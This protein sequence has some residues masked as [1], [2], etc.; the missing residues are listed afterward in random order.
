MLTKLPRPGIAASRSTGILTQLFGFRS[1]A[2]ILQTQRTR[3]SPKSIPSAANLNAL[4]KNKAR[5]I[6]EFIFQKFA[7]T[8]CKIFV[9]ASGSMWGRVWRNT[10]LMRGNLIFHRTYLYPSKCLEKCRRFCCGIMLYNPKRSYSLPH[11]WF[12]ANIYMR[13]ALE[14]KQGCSKWPP[15][16]ILILI[17]SS[18]QIFKYFSF[19]HSTN[20]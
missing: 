3:S 7:S 19:I 18:V 20:M 13:A 17:P 15:E 1:Y 4:L 10:V 5:K 9:L 6:T 16:I 8:Q 14:V 11:L 2:L 12:W